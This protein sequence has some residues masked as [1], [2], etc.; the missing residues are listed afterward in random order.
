MTTDILDST[1]YKQASNNVLKIEALL[2]WPYYFSYLFVSLNI[3][4]LVKQN[5]MHLVTTKIKKK[6]YLPEQNCVIL[7]YILLQLYWQQEKIGKI[8][9]KF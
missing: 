6:Q 1:A 7:N 4:H 5:K 3:E 2:N 8:G 9:R